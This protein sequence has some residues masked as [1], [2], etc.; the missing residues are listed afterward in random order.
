[1]EETMKAALAGLLHDVGK[2]AQRAGTAGKHAE[3]GANII[4]G[5]F[6]SLWPPG[7]LDDI[8]DA[9][10]NHHGGDTHKS[11][12]KAVRVAD[13]LASAER[14]KGFT[15]QGRP[16]TTPLVPITARVELDRVFSED[17]SLPL[18]DLRIMPRELT[19]DVYPPIFPNRQVEVTTKEYGRLWDAFLDEIQTL[20]VPL[21]SLSRFVGLMSVLRRYTSQIPSATPWE[22]EEADR[23]VPDVS[24][25][26]H[27]KVTAAISSCLTRILPDHLDNLHRIGWRSVIQDERPVAQLLRADFSGIQAFIYRIVTPERERLH[28]ATAKRLRGRS[29][30]LSILLEVVVDWFLRTLE[31]TSANALFVGGG[32]FDLLIPVDQ[33]TQETV[34]QL[35]Q[36]LQSWLTKEFAGVLGL[37][38]ACEMMTPGDFR[39]MRRVNAALDDK[40]AVVKR[41]KFNTVL[42]PEFFGPQQ[43]DH[44]CDVCGLTPLKT[45]AVAEQQICGVCHRHERIGQ[46]LPKTIYLARIYGSREA[47]ALKH[48]SRLLLNFSAPIDINVA[49]L[50]SERDVQL[51]LGDIQEIDLETTVYSLNGTPTPELTWPRQSAPARQYLANTVPQ[52]DGIVCEFEDIAKFSTGTKLLGVLKADLDH[53][54]LVFSLGLEPPTISRVAALSHMFD[55][56]FSGYLNTLC[57]AVT[58]RWKAGSLD[59]GEAIAEDLESLFYTVYAGGDDLLI[60]GPWDQT[61]KLAQELY[62]DFRAYTC[63]NPNLTLSAG[64]ALVKP[65]FPV[66]RFVALADEALER[67]KNPAPDSQGRNRITVFEETPTVW[68]DYGKPTAFD[69]LMKLADELLAD[70]EARNMPRTLLHDMEQMRRIEVKTYD[71]GSKPM[72][73]PQLLYLLTRRLPK[74]VRDKYKKR[75]LDAWPGIRIPIS[76]VSLS[77]R[78]E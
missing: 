39:N 2:F 25:Y 45:T 48:S 14:A 65:H 21:D 33:K 17:W 15:E 23:T 69:E 64:I 13:W 50:R 59:T 11:V 74:P 4:E 19:D 5:E 29:F 18:Q 16:N 51:L 77:T 58:E 30:H 54:G 9:V 42:S 66:Q 3:V 56:F 28:R 26:D 62:A 60:I 53:L 8:D 34:T 12:V 38:L 32:R 68:T 73:T 72:V 37:E 7:W 43:L 61:I 57:K 27:L 70:V 31:L 10:A 41:Q 20:P 36:K 22:D 35:T 44:V 6:Q 71:S 55:R 24:L 47:S 1:M 67:A 46:T 52:A 75:I 76:Y 78:K 63:Q 40:L 49:L